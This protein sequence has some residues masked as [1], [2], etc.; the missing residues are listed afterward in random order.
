M[1]LIILLAVICFYQVF[2]EVSDDVKGKFYDK[3]GLCCRGCKGK[4]MEPYN[5]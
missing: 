3:Q 5:G 1:K 4:H 2:A